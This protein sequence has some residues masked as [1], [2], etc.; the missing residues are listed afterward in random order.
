MRMK[1]NKDACQIRI[2]SNNI[3]YVKLNKNRSLFNGY[4]GLDKSHL[5]QKKHKFHDFLKAI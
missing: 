1:A 3:V 4:Y 2:F 5:T